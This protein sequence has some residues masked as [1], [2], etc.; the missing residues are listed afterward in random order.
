[1]HLGHFEKIWSWKGIAVD[2]IKLLED[3]DP[4]NVATELNERLQGKVENIF[5]MLAQSLDQRKTAG[6]TEKCQVDFLAHLLWSSIG[7]LTY[8]TFI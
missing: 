3:S 7:K 6:N 4:L 1:M 8:Y 2:V 5:I